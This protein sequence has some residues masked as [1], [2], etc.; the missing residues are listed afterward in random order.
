MARGRLSECLH[1]I[2]RELADAGAP[3]HWITGNRHVV[4][5]DTELDTDVRDFEN[6]VAGA[7]A[8]VSPERQIELLEQALSLY[9][10]GLLPGMSGEWVAG[11]RNRMLAIYETAA[12]QLAR[13]LQMAGAFEA[14]PEFAQ[15]MTPEDLA[16]QWV[17]SRSLQTGA[18]TT[19]ADSW[20][21]R[22]VDPRQVTGRA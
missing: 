13:S 1:Y 12:R 21:Q 10:E 11:E 17:K 15:H 14:T 7:I 5:L 6:A 16:R 4:E 22:A 18:G 20:R 3:P 2:K 9:G 19:F 8:G